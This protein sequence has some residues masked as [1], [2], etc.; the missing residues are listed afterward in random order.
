MTSGRYGVADADIEI[1]RR[2]LHELA[3]ARDPTTFAVLDRLGVAAGGE[4][5]E[6]GAGAGTVSRGL[7]E[8][9]GPAGRVW[10]LD[11]DVRFHDPMPAN[12]DV[13]A[14]DITR[15]DLPAAHF[16]VVHAR[17]V[18][19]H[20]PEREAVLDR[21]VAATKPGGWVVVEDGDMR[22][23]VEQPL[24]EPFGTVHRLLAG[25]ASTPWRD[26][27][28][29]SR[30][31]ALMADRGLA[32]IDVHGASTAMRPHEPSGEWW[33]LAI[34]RMLPQLVEQAVISRADSDAVREQMRAPG[35]VMLGPLSLAVWGRR[36][37][38]S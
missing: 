37:A 36:P 6:V 33:F 27:H 25:G 17:A 30:L 12:V 5:L 23:F 31:V 32:G 7:A 1:E 24:P 28:L 26:P 9:V 19:Q 2:R 34:E 21:L 38:A 3:A 13:R 14:H 29:G 15:D 10:S 11:I 18:L 8:R 35:F 16:D 4:C 20:I 22:A